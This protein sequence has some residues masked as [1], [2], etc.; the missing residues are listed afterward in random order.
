MQG[1]QYATFRG[2][3]LDPGEIDYHADYDYDEY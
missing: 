3:D 1:C 2:N